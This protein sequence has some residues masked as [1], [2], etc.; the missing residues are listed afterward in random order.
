MILACDTHFDKL[1]SSVKFNLEAIEYGLR[2]SHTGL[3]SIHEKA[4]IAT[5][6]NETSLIDHGQKTKENLKSNLSLFHRYFYEWC[7]KSAD[8]VKQWVLFVE[9]SNFTAARK[10]S[11]GKMVNLPVD[12]IKYLL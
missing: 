8:F 12:H 11:F 7:Q 5:T 2:V 10:N 1:S 4:K 6:I 9:I 3:K